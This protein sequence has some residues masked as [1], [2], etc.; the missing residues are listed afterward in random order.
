VAT[1]EA[2]RPGTGYNVGVSSLED[3]NDAVRDLID[4]VRTLD[5]PA[6]VATGALAQVR[7]VVDDL[8]PFA[9]RGPHQQ[10]T[11]RT[12][13]DGSARLEGSD[14]NQFFPYSPVV[15][16]L[17]PIAPPVRTW[18]DGDKLRGEVVFGAAYNGPMGAV[19]GGVIALVFD[20]LLGSANVV[21]GVGAF[22]GTLSVRYERLTPLDAPVEMEAWVDRTD[23]RKVFTAGVMRHGGAVTARAEGVFI[24]SGALPGRP[25]AGDG[26]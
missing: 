2:S 1:D 21:H 13:E 6:G 4:R 7:A 26:T 14:P 10:S 22:T 25:V 8:T 18:I 11:L 15:G 17:N 5:A 24:Q 16:A 12:P 3:L 19:H 9:Y 20:E 23:G